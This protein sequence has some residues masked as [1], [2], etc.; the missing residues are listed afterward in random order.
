[1]NDFSRSAEKAADE[2][3]KALASVDEA[4]IEMLVKEILRARKVFFIAAGRSGYVLRCVA[5][6]FYHVGLDAHFVGDVNVPPI[7]KR[8]LLIVGSASGE[9]ICPAAIAK[10]AKERR[11]RLAYIGCGMTSRLR[12]MADVFV[13]L[14]MP[15][16]SKQLMES[17]FEQSLL[18]L[19]DV[20]ALMIA[21]ETKASSKFIKARHANLE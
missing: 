9:R 11:A 4:Q 1:M 12:R 3:A 16:K 6:R 20:L 10:A 19:G 17:L 8:D 21:R 14:P 5:S 15:V 18:V 2:I 13:R 7:T